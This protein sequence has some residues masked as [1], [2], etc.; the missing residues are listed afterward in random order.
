[1]SLIWIWLI[2]KML[3]NVLNTLGLILNIPDTFLALTLLSVGNS[4]GG[5]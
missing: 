1:M 2:A 3:I 5:I 4:A